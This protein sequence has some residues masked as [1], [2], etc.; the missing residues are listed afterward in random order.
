MECK[1]VTVSR[2][3]P[4]SFELIDTLWNVNLDNIYMNYIFL[5]ELIDTLWNV[6]SAEA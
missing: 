3:N 5:S 6:N 1:C 2:F 4:V